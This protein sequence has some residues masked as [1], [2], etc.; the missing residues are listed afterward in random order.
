MQVTSMLSAGYLEPM[1]NV[2]RVQKLAEYE[3]DTDQ[4]KQLKEQEILAE[5]QALKAKLGD[6]AQV[7]TVYHYSLGSDGKRYITGASVTMKGSEEDLNRVGGGLA[8]EDIQ[9]RSRE[10]SETLRKD[11]EKN[12]KNQ[13]VIK[14]EDDKRKAEEKKD[15]AED[16]KDS[17]VRELKQIQQEVIAHEAAHQAAAGELGGSV[18][19]TYTQG[20]DGQ[21]YITGGEVPIRFKEGATPEET[22]RNMQKVQAAANAPADPSGQDMK[23][24]AKAAALAAA[25][26]REISQENEQEQHTETVARGTPVFQ[27]AKEAESQQDPEKNGVMSILATVK[28]LQIMSM[29]PAA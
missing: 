28:E 4:S 20:P 17:Q 13:T 1:Q 18:S 25:A 7:H 21:R 26:R 9:S 8:T 29:I 3:K 22:L 12:E 6:S 14:A 10:V 19:Y 2:S 16:E 24:A 27:S 11:S 23:V 5:E 15:K